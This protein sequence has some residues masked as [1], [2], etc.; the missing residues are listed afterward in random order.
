MDISDTNDI[1]DGCEYNLY[2]NVDE[3]FINMFLNTNFVCC[4]VYQ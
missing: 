3:Y 4:Y 2:L 1:A